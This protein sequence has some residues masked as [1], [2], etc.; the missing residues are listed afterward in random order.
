MN[1]AKFLGTPFSQ[2]TSGRLLL[3]DEASVSTSHVV[4]ASSIVDESS[5]I[6]VIP[7]ITTDRLSCNSTKIGE[8]SSTSSEKRGK[9]SSK[10]QKPLATDDM[11]YQPRDPKCFLDR[12][13]INHDQNHEDWKTWLHYDQEKDIVFCFTCIKAAEQNLIS[14]KNAE[15]AFI[16][17]G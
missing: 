13:N 12:G 8:L 7:T 6:D 14:S 3:I 2:N 16:S 17:V 4:S 1:F 10:I 11:P 5:T 9:R 15:K